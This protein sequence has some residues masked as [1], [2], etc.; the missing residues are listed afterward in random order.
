MIRFAPSALLL[1]AAISLTAQTHHAGELAL[2]P[3]SFRTYDGSAH[4]AE[5]GHLWVRENRKSGSGRLIEIAFVRLRTTAQKPRS[6]LVFLPGGPGIPGAVLGRVPVYFQLLEKIQA[7]SDVILADQRGVGMSSPNTECPEGAPPAPD[8]FERESSVLQAMAARA[9]ACA[10][11]WHG[12][13]VDLAAYTTEESADDL[14]ELRQAIG[15]DKLSLLAHSYGTAL[16]IAAMRRHGEHLDRVVLAGVEGPDENL[17]LPLAFDFALRRVSEAAANS[18]KV[19]GAFPDTYGEFQKVITQLEREPLPVRIRNERTRQEVEVKV[20]AFPAQFAIKGMLSN[21]RQVGR[22]P[23]LVYSLAHRDPALLSGAVQ[24]FYNGL[25]SGFTAMQFA[26]ACS[27]GWSSARR[28]LGGE[29]S[30]RSLFGDVPFAHLDPQICEGAG[31]GAVAADSLLPVWRSV[32]TLL[33]EGTL[34]GNTP[35][36]QAERVGWGLANAEFVTVENG[37][38]E[39]LPADEVQAMVAQFLGGGQIGR[40]IMQLPA[41]VFLTIEEAKASEQSSH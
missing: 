4:P 2:E 39:T 33:V 20:G 19:R 12:K 23:A 10:D 22:V 27:D 15:A 32:P 38:H 9:R 11:H 16:A 5:L 25:I 37:F 21:G 1:L 6:P 35:I 26:V 24:D 7:F 29:Q 31:A 28:E 34:D 8:V 18:A 17:Q 40:R 3:Y 13:D 30:L 41:P 14:E 36:Y